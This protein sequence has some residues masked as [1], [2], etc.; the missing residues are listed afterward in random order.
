MGR[1]DSSFLICWL[2]RDS[3]SYL[4]AVLSFL[5]LI[6]CHLNSTIHSSPAGSLARGEGK[7]NVFSGVRTHCYKVW[8]R[9]CGG[10]GQRT[11][12]PSLGDGRDGQQTQDREY[13]SGLY[14]EKARDSW[15]SNQHGPVSFASSPQTLWTCFFTYK[16]IRDLRLL[17]VVH[18]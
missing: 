1:A 10:R 5:S 9:V 18:R 7:N 6:C 15:H 17:G 12:T 8:A 4:E 13:V 2:N 3:Q 11:F 14:Q 16:A